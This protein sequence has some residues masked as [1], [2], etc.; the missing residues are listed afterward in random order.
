MAA[1][2]LVASLVVQFGGKSLKKVLLVGTLGLGR[3]GHVDM[4]CVLMDLRQIVCNDIDVGCRIESM[5]V[6]AW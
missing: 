3:G 4:V 6:S 5:F 2:R 1:G